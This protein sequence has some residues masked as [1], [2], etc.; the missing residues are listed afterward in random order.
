MTQTT[1]AFPAPSR[2]PIDGRPFQ[3][4]RTVYRFADIPGDGSCTGTN[5]SERVFIR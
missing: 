2:P 3:I 1:K 5:R 4:P